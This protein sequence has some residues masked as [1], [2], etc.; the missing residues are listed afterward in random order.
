MKKILVVLMALLA[1]A[2][3]V[4]G[5]GGDAKK[6]A[7]PADGDITV[8]LKGGALTISYDKATSDVYM[9]GE[10]VE[11]YRGTVEI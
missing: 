6:A 1:M 9:T 5:C 2:V 10:A 3:M 8:H 11:V 4:T 7:Y